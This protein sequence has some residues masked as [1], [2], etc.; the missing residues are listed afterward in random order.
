MV[1]SNSKSSISSQGI[2]SPFL[3]VPYVW[4]DVLAIMKFCQGGHIACVPFGGGTS[5]VGGV[6]PPHEGYAG[7]IAVDLTRHFNKVVI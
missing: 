2:N 4:P 1:T 6:E 3:T 5:V 7:A